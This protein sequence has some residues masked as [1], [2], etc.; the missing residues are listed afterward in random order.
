MNGA[1]TPG[2][3]VR[4]L[5]G[6]IRRWRRGRVDTSLVEAIG[7]AYVAIFSA[8][9]LGSMAISV[10]VNLRVV[11]AGTCSSVSCLD[12]RDAVGWL[13]GLAALTLVLAAARLIGPMLTSPAVGT[14]LLTAPLDRTALVRGR[15][16]GTTI[17]A[18]LTGAVL[19]ATGAALSA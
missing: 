12:A 3:E 9:V 19:T 10:V 11:T 4:E 13:S 18:A 5:R 8:I 2:A 6:Q 7:D 17:A 14:W 16:V 1:M 15:L